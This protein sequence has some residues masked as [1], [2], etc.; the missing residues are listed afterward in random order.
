MSGNGK[1]NTVM[2]YNS[3]G[4]ERIPKE[5]KKFIENKKMK[6]NLYRIQVYYSIMDEYF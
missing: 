3:F 6:T 2:Y 4:V 5:I 1:L